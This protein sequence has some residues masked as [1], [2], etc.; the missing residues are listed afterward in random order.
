M[1]DMQSI[2]DLQIADL[3]I[4]DLQAAL[5][6][7]SEKLKS[8]GDLAMINN[9]LEK[10]NT[11]LGIKESDKKSKERVISDL[12]NKIEELKG[13]LYGGVITSQKELQALDE[14]KDYTFGE[15]TSRED[16]LLE[17][18]IEIEKFIDSRDKHRSAADKLIEKK[19]SELIH[20]SVKQKELTLALDKQKLEREALARKISGDV[21]ALYEKLKKNKAGHAVSK[22]EGHLCGVCRVELPVK[23]LLDAKSGIR[24][25][26]CN[27]CRRIIYVS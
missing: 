27:S 19:S 6:V 16:D 15:L 11:A 10:I 12:V 22:L 18:M 14:Q 8:D 5:A 24:L 26:Q 25:V 9:R 1:N 3:Q 7:I 4:G 17:V 13:L 21:I 20:L 2:F 23:E